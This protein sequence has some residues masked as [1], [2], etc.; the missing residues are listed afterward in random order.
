MPGSTSKQ[1]REDHCPRA[2]RFVGRVDHF[3]RHRRHE[4]G[5]IPPMDFGRIADLVGGMADDFHGHIRTKQRR[6]FAD[7]PGRIVA[8]TFAPTARRRERLRIL[9]VPLRIE[10]ANPFRERRVRGEQACSRP[11]RNTCGSARPP[12]GW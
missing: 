8:P 11:R 3:L 7:E 2:V 4:F 6:L 10:P 12:A 5:R 9:A 1:R